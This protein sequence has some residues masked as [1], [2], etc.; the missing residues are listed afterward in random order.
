MTVAGCVDIKQTFALSDFQHCGQG[1]MRDSWWNML[2]DHVCQDPNK[3]W[4]G[5]WFPTIM[6][7]AWNFSIWTAANTTRAS[8]Q[9]GREWCMFFDVVTAIVVGLAPCETYFWIFLCKPCSKD[10]LSIWLTWRSCFSLQFIRHC[11]QQST[12]AISAWQ[13]W[14]QLRG[15]SLDRLL[16]G[17]SG[18]TRFGKAPSKAHHQSSSIMNHESGVQSLESESPRYIIDKLFKFGTWSLE[19]WSWNLEQF[20]LWIWGPT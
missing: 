16:D 14:L 5:N 18:L 20:G 8:I 13:T 7:W 1:S 15:C 12:G 4:Q 3:I 19:A 17:R 9:N 6:N 10:P 2:K 11:R